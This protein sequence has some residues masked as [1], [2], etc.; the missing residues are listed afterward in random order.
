MRKKGTGEKTFWF[1]CIKKIKHLNS[2]S[3]QVSTWQG[4]KTWILIH[5]TCTK[6]FRL[7]LCIVGLALVSTLN[8][9][10]QGGGARGA[11][12]WM[13]V[14]SLFESR[15]CFTEPH[16]RSLTDT[17]NSWGCEPGPKPQLAATGSI[18]RTPLT[19]KHCLGEHYCQPLQSVFNI[20]WLGH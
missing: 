17:M 10:S 18:V 15:Y 4:I 8:P 14:K 5:D 20:S 6:S 2:L 9:K 12:S 16:L 3:V 7:L 13:G 1:L 11:S 19:H